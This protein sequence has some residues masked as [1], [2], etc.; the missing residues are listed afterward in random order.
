MVANPSKAKVVDFI[1][2]LFAEKGRANYSGEPVSQTEHALQAAW[3][4]EKQNATPSLVVAALLHDIGHLLHDLGE[5][6]AD[7]GIDDLHEEQGAHWLCNYF[8]PEATEPIRLHVAA[9]RYRCAVDPKYRKALSPASVQS[10]QLQGGPFTPDEVRE[11]EALPY[12]QA[13]LQLR[14]WDEIAKVQNLDT[15]DLEYFRKY[16]VESVTR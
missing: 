15:P 6:C 14:L 16:L 11:F 2:E 4:A 5:D 3:A 1:V 12:A 10:L 9:K 13:A 8:G 7:E